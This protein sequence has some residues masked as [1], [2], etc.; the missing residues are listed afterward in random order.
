[1]K[2]TNY[3]KSK[4]S[5]S[6]ET[7]RRLSLY[8]RNLRGLKQRGVKI[9]SSEE[10]TRFLNISSPQFRKDL[11]Y[12][13][14]FG[15]R[16]VGYEV[17][18]LAQEI[19]KILGINKEWKI[20][21]VGV[22]GLGSAL[23][24]FPGFSKFNEKITVVFDNDA[25]KINKVKSGIKIQDINEIQQT[26]SKKNIKIVMICVSP[27]NAQEI[28][29]KAIKANARAILNF[30]PVSLKVPK[31]VYVANVDMS[32]ELETLIYFLNKSGI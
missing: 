15:K 19:E 4:K 20:A 22:G 10:I 26:L 1:M 11:S 30:A 2:K 3:T 21:L 14:E 16:G 17:D 29:D 24:K 27:E 31:N 23:L 5:F 32:C 12:F 9:V 18:K 8:L 6:P 28:A 13:G 25:G 7:I